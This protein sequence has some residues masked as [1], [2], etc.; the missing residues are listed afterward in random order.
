M[1]PMSSMTQAVTA[2]ASAAAAATT[3][4]ASSAVSNTE[5]AA[6]NTVSGAAH[7][8][9][10]AA[11]NTVSGAAN[12]AANTVKAGVAKLNK[13]V[14]F[15]SEA[16]AATHCPNDTVVWSTLS[17]NGSFHTSDSKLFGKTKH[18]AYVCKADAVAA[19]FHQAKN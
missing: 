7:S 11:T 19:G 15:K 14:E 10:A 3:S 12:A 1:S 13:A 17:K 5:A 18:G 8:A 6:A 16:E 4:A 9:T 2:P